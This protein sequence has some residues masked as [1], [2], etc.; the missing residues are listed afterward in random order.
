MKYVNNKYS[1]ESVSAKSNISKMKKYNTDYVLEVNTEWRINRA[2]IF[3]GDILGITN[4][5]RL[6]DRKKMVIITQLGC[7]YDTFT[8]H[9]GKYNKDDYYAYNGKLL[10]EITSKAI[11]ECIKEVK[12]KARL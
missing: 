9:E 2:N 8:N 1:P 11:D 5:I 4:N 7:V 12:L 3:M 10:K 6:I